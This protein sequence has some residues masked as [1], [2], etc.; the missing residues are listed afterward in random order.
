MKLGTTGLALAA[1]LAL[2][3][4]GAPGA[5]TAQTATTTYEITV[6]N[7]TEA[8][9]F[10]PPL[11]ATHKP[12]VHLWQLGQPASD[13]IWMV[14]ESGNAGVLAEQARGQATEVQRAAGPIL[15]KA[16][17]TLRVAAERGDV[18]SLAAMLAETNDGFV[19]LDGLPLEAGSADLLA[20]DAGTE[21]NTERATDVPG[22]PYGGMGHQ[23][24]VPAQPIAP[25]PGILGVGDVDPKFNWSG[26][27]ARVTVSVVTAE[28]PAGGEAPLATAP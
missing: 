19:G 22:P 14:A 8:Q 11:V 18:L 9:I 16:S 23:A 7:L 28:R 27:V 20:Y 24:T 6:T 15:P 26:P 21:E 3:L 17:L 25:H 2:G 13:G 4:S 5:A 10:S 12:A 1:S